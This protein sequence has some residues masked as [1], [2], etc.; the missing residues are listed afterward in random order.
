MTLPRLVVK[1]ILEGLEQ[2][3]MDEDGIFDDKK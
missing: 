2:F 3:E 1:I